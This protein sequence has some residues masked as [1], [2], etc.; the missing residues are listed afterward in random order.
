MY[1]LTHNDQVLVGPMVWNA[2]MFNAV[3]EDDLEIVTN[4]LPSDVSKV[5]LDLGNGLMIREC[6][7]NY[8]TLNTKTQM[9]NGPFWN[10]TSVPAVAQYV[11]VDKPLDLVRQELKTKVADARWVLE[12]KGTTA[13]I[14]GQTVTVDTARGS[15]DVFV[16]Q[17]LLMPST[18]TSQWKFPEGW[19][20]VTKDDLGICVQAGVSHVQ[21]AF[22]WEATVGNT[23]NSAT[24]LAQLDAIVITT[25]N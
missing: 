3:I 11:V 16:Q 24:T 8:P 18:T 21:N 1:V 13:V 14:Q 7:D 15:R 22:G 17:F 6:V 23:I 19:L 25:G 9:Y 5:P 12:Q 20:V 2:R 4:I 10:F